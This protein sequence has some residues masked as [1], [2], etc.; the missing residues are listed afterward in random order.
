MKIYFTLGW[1]FLFFFA[2]N[3]SFAQE[4]GVA[5]NIKTS[6]GENQ[7]FR[8]KLVESLKERAFPNAV[9]YDWEPN[10]KLT[11]VPSTAYPEKPC[12]KAVFVEQILKC[13]SINK[14]EIVTQKDT[15]GNVTSAYFKTFYDVSYIIKSIDVVTGEVIA[16]PETLELAGKLNM[17]SPLKIDVKKYYGKTPPVS[18]SKRPKSRTAI[19]YEDYKEK[20]VKK[21]NEHKNSKLG[22]LYSVRKNIRSTIV[23]DIYTVTLDPIEKKLYRSVSL[24]IK[25]KTPLEKHDILDLFTVLDVAGKEA[26]QHVTFVEVKSVTGDVAK[27]GKTFIQGKKKFSK[28]LAK[29]KQL[30]AVKNRNTAFNIIANDRKKVNMALDADAKYKLNYERRMLKLPVVS[31]IERGFAKELASLRSLYKNEKYIDYDLSEAQDRLVG[32]E[33][34][35]TIEKENVNVTDVATGQLV[36]I[37]KEEGR[38][39]WFAPGY[40]LVQALN[41]SLMKISNS[42]IELLEVV[43]QKKDKVKKIRLYNPVG[44]EVRDKIDI[45]A[46][47]SEVVAGK[48]FERKKYI[49]NGWVSSKEEN[50]NFGVM[51]IGKKFRKAVAKAIAEGQKLEFIYS[52]KRG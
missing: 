13:S 31:V 4:L 48:T 23:D 12:S 17:I 37:D 43:D 19:I 2:A 10:G 9:I 50:P 52:I 22:G 5:I 6:T 36:A 16:I 33:Y 34:L 26:V 18:K 29:H 11:Y 8:N 14:P 25:D 1:I 3:T 32:V 42:P 45:S 35:V 28:R 21:F 41:M 47:V 30:Y 44:F 20:L 51:K 27:A 40:T 15:S 38:R 46:V 39:N 24:D 7:D 49:G